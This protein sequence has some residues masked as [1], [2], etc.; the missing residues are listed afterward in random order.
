MVV[1][2]I[3]FI[4]AK[5]SKKLLESEAF[6]GRQRR[7]RQDESEEGKVNEILKYR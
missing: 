4:F 5:E 7:K 2:N 6:N 1:S 3:L